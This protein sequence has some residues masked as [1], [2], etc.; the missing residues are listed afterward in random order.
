MTSAAVVGGGL[1]HSA[2]DGPLR[3]R[4]VDAGGVMRPATVVLGWDGTVAT[5]RSTF[6]GPDETLPG[7]TLVIAETGVAETALAD[8]LRSRAIP[9]ETIGDCVAPRRASLAIY[10]GRE[11]A[12]RV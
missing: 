3:R 1:F 2:A 6:G 7:D 9:F 5:I 11:L 10:E 12:L 8:E 4:F